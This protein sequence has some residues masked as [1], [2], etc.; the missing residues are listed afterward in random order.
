MSGSAPNRSGPSVSDAM[1]SL[2]AATNARAAW[3]VFSFVMVALGVGAYLWMQSTPVTTPG[4][5]GGSAAVEPGIPSTATEAWVKYV[6]DGDTLFLQDGRKVRLLGINTPE[7]GA[8]LECYGNEATAALRA[9]LPKGTHVWVQP[10][11]EP[12]DQYGRSLLFIYMDDATNVNLAL[13]A[14]GDAELMQFEPNYLLSD[15]LHAAE[16]AARD[17]GLGLWGAC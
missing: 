8:H 9:M 17:A 10:D 3:P 13:L 14:Q 16:S 12:L 7:I 11:L 2:R 6:H 1:R 5:G 4:M 15:Q